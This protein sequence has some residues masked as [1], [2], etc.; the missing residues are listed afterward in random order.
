MTIE[1]KPI[2]EQPKWVALYIN[3]TLGKFRPVGV[4][5]SEE[6]AEEFCDRQRDPALW[7]S[8]ALN[9]R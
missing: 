3:C 8:F 9:R 7:S 1:S 2:S 5:D 6:E 4:F